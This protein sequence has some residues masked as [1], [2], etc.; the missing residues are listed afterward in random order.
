M[1]VRRRLKTQT[2]V[3]LFNQKEVRKYIYTKPMIPSPSHMVKSALHK[4]LDV[5]TALCFL[6]LQEAATRPCYET[7]KN[8]RCT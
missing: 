2:L 4:A 7:K 5:F 6:R 1:H 3:L 8:Y